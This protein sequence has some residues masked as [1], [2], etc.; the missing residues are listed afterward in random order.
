MLPVILTVVVLDLH[1]SD[2]LILTLKLH[3]NEYR[4]AQRQLQKNGSVRRTHYWAKVV[5]L[6]VADIME[7]E[8]VHYVLRV[9]VFLI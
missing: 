8:W 5:I 6:V 1:Q 3:A 4:I 9:L 7:E 2:K